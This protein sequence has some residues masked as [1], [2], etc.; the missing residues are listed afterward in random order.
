[1]TL[2]NHLDFSM[3]HYKNEARSQW[4]LKLSFSAQVISS[5]VSVRIGRCEKERRK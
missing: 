3:H 5:M 2:R 1:M 4:I